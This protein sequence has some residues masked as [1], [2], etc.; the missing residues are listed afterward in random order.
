MSEVKEQCPRCGEYTL[1]PIEV[2]NALCRRDNKTYICSPC[3]SEQAMEDYANREVN[4]NKR[5]PFVNLD[6]PIVQ[7]IMLDNELRLQKQVELLNDFKNYID[8]V[9]EEIEVGMMNGD[10]SYSLK[11]S[12][13]PLSFWEFSEAVELEGLGFWMNGGAK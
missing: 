7:S 6:N 3:G 8:E 1:H 2:M 4:P 13:L 9:I 10:G 5:V 12:E 11:E